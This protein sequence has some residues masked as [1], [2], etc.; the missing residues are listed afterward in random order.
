VIGQGRWRGF[1]FL[2]GG[3][4]CFLLASFLLWAFSGRFPEDGPTTEA[5]PSLGV[6]SREVQAEPVAAPL[7]EEEWVVY[8]TG[9]V[10]RPGVYSLPAGSRVYQLVEKSGGLTSEADAESINLAAK[11]ADGVHVHVPKKGEAKLPA[12]GFMAHVSQGKGGFLGSTSASLIDINRASKEDLERLPGI[13]PKTAEAITA[14]RESHGLFERVE[15]L[16]QV[17][18]IGP[19]K[20]EAIRNLITVGSP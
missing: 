19:K 16:L 2:A 10:A 5:G 17:K 8:V 9:A 3:V 14:Y 18:G 4:G 7:R 13:G 20:L 15:D 6:R 1:L 12:Q 11:L